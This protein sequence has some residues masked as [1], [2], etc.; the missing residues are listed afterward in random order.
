MVS[1]SHW[2]NASMVKCSKSSAKSS[3]RVC[4][5]FVEAWYFLVLH[6]VNST[7]SSVDRLSGLHPSLH[8][9]VMSDAVDSAVGESAVGD[10]GPVWARLRL[11]SMLA[12][13]YSDTL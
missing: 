10:G 6:L 2:L 1:L 7:M 3:D 5:L 13:V 8:F 12:V 11:S 9:L 4:P